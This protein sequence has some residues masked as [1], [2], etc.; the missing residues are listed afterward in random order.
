VTK[1]ADDIAFSLETTD[2]IIAEAR[3]A[4]ALDHLKRLFEL[5]EAEPVHLSHKEL[6]ALSGET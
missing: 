2:R 6:V 4:N 5:T 3:Q 1:I